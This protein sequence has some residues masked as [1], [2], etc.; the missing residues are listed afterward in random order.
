[1]VLAV[2]KAAYSFFL[3]DLLTAN[4]TGSSG[5]VGGREDAAAV[6]VPGHAVAGAAAAWI[7]WKKE[8]SKGRSRLVKSA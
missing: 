4:D 3:L 2:A 8:R 1:M 6:P 5:E 7:E